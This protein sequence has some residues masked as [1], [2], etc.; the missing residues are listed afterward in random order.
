MLRLRERMKGGEEVDK[1]PFNIAF[2]LA[3][4]I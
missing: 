3:M 2:L 4:T 1:L